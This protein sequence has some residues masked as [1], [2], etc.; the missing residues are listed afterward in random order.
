MK[1]ILFLFLLLLSAQILF[2]ESRYIVISNSQE[3]SNY[4]IKDYDDGGVFE[5]TNTGSLNVSSCSFVNNKASVGG[6]ILN[7]GFL[8]INNPIIS[9][10][11][12]DD[13]TPYFS[14]NISFAGGAIYNEGIMNTGEWIY[15]C[16]NSSSTASVSAG[17]AVYSRGIT[18]I[19]SLNYFEQNTSNLG[20]AI[21]IDS[22]TTTISNMVAFT[23]NSADFGGAI[24]A[25][26]GTT[27][28]ADFVFFTSNT[29]TTTGGAIFAD[30]NSKILISSANYF[31]WNK[32][33]T[34]TGGA[35]YNSGIMSIGAGQETSL[36]SFVENSAQ[37]GGAVYNNNFLGFADVGLFGN[38]KANFAGGAVCNM[39]DGLIL[40]DKIHNF[41][42]NS[43]SF[44]GGAIFN[45]SGAVLLCD[46]ANFVNNKADE[47]GGAIYNEAKGGILLVAKTKDILFEGNTANGISNAIYDDGGEI[48]L[49]ASS[50]ASVIFNDRIVSKDNTSVL[51]INAESPQSQQNGMIFSIDMPRTGKIVLNEDMSGYMG[52][53]NLCGGRIQLGEN[54]TLFGGNYNIKN[55]AVIDM[56][57]TTIQE[58]NFNKL[59]ADYRFDLCVD[60]DL[61][62]KKMD[63]ISAES[64]NGPTIH[65]K[66]INVVNDTEET[67]TK[68]L[69]TSSTVLKD[70][71]SAIDNVSSKL[72]KYDVSYNDGYFNFINV[73]NKINP[74]LA[75]SAIASSVGGFT[76]QTN[77]LGQAF[78]SIDNMVGSRKSLYQSSNHPILK[79][80]NLYASASS[81]I[82]DMENKIERGL[83]IRPY[84]VQE[85]I[86][87]NDIDVDN[88]AIGT[89]A[90][91][92]LATGENTLLSFYLGY[93]GS[94]QKYED[95]KVNQTGYIVGA[96]GMIIKEKWYAGITANINFNKAQSQS[97]YGTDNFDM[98]M[99]SI[100]AKA[101]YNFDLSDK[102]ILE[103]NLM[104]MYGNVNSQEYE[105]TQGAKI[106]SQSIANIIVE[107]QVKAKLS[108]ENGWQPYGLVGYV[109]NI[110]DKAK[111]V[112]DETEFETDKIDGYVEYGLGVNKE[113]E[114]TP[115]SFY[116]QATGR[117]GGRTGFAGNLGIKYK[118]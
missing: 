28:I 25:S 26:S 87:F 56:V 22:G 44:V 23:Q 27:N 81:S 115:W 33:N 39:E 6:A 32:A 69:F 73:S 3:I 17:G 16:N 74:V 82:F 94:N 117:S 80:S 67:K 91:L 113:F 61:E 18:N 116:A 46:G 101:G 58:H 86:K 111:V 93:A 24:V 5:I 54:G 59:T 55:Y 103:P 19:G 102:W 64:Y 106:D 62:N 89:L 63:T 72:Y 84:A 78:S 90:G 2:A 1:K 21:Y 104:L 77:V 95:I 11:Y 51:N 98:N 47:F 99:Y 96:M 112:V 79:S 15:F 31:T 34:G 29:A 52:T 35:I 114:F 42:S 38:N 109:A 107:P 53:V 43:S 14:N 75:E 83:W 45:S 40:F 36:T 10:E 108:L 92:D 66:A 88:T 65:V 4:L 8:E 20:G 68:V 85:T 50:D 57:N 13:I 100:G 37:S 30:K 48:Y 97:D 71:I 76:T 49:N 110:S 105:T 9:E 7:K 41:I 118:F 12:E 60:A 70:K